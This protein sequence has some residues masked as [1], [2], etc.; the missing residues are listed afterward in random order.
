MSDLKLLQLAVFRPLLK[1]VIVSQRNVN[2]ISYISIL[3]F[4]ENYGLGHK[5]EMGFSLHRSLDTHVIRILRLFNL[6]ELAF[7]HHLTQKDQNFLSYLLKYLW[8]CF[9]YYSA[10]SALEIERKTDFQ[11]SVFSCSYATEKCYQIC[12]NV[13]N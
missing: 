7:W 9:C 1:K 13:F 3:Q 4:G 12:Q 6:W 10:Q 11:F 2:Q 5:G 8:R